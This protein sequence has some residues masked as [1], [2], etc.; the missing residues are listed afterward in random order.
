LF[1]SVESPARVFNINVGATK[2]NLAIEHQ[3]KFGTVYR[4]VQQ[5]T[6]EQTTVGQIYKAD[7]LVR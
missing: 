6:L 1:T 4:A 3:H 7:R 2:I 5:K